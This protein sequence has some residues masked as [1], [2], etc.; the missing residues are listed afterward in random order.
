MNPYTGDIEPHCI[1]YIVRK[2]PNNDDDDGMRIEYITVPWSIDAIGGNVADFV[3]HRAKLESILPPKEDESLP[4]L[5]LQSSHAQQFTLLEDRD[6]WSRG[7]IPAGTVAE[8]F[9]P[10]RGTLVV[11]DSVTLPH[12]VTAVI[13]G[14]RAALAGW[15][16]EETQPL[17]G[18]IQ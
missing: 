5:F 14:R 1:L 6:G 15:F 10:T 12:E 7:E 18:D 3:Q 17:G 11:F 16:H 4:S 9:V 13:T 2:S 8:D